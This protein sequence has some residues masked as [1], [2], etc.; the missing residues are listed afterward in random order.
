MI[1]GIGA[2]LSGLLNIS[3]VQYDKIMNMYVEE[4]PDS[5]SDEYFTE[6]Q[7]DAIRKEMGGEDDV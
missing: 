5:H 3:N 2:L 7:L 1:S 4:P 6:E